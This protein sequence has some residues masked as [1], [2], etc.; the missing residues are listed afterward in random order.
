MP[1]DID[2]ANAAYKGLT[3]K[4][5]VVTNG[6]YQYIVIPIT[7]ELSDLVEAQ[8]Q[9]NTKLTHD[10]SSDTSNDTGV[11]GELAVAKFLGL[12]YQFGKVNNGKADL[13]LN[14]ETGAT[15]EVKSSLIPAY[16]KIETLH[17]LVKSTYYYRDEMLAFREIGKNK[18]NKEDF[19]NRLKQ[20]F[21]TKATAYTSVMVVQR[22]DSELYSSKYE[23]DFNNMQYRDEIWLANKFK[24]LVLVGVISAGKFE[25]QVKLKRHTVNN[26]Y[27]EDAHYLQNIHIFTTMLGSEQPSFRAAVQHIHLAS[28]TNKTV[29]E[30][31]FNDKPSILVKRYKRIVEVK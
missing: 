8:K 31:M 10:I 16:W 22:T 19:L 26:R 7:Q 17:V 30:A 21:T 23:E 12:H 28:F 3:L 25:Q 11:I 1:I 6:N 29:L 5:K 27:A 9:L 14:T 15:L 18:G 13:V 4:T 20:G 24:F 2:S